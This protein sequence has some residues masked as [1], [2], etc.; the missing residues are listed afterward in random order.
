MQPARNGRGGRR[1]DGTEWDKANPSDWDPFGGLDKR[2]GPVDGSK[3]TLGE[4]DGPSDG[5]PLGGLDERNG[6]KDGSKDKLGSLRTE[7]ITVWLR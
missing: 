2:D 6:S 1:L 3:D 7:N 5:D 4:E